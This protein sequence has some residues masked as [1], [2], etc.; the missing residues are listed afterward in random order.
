MNNSETLIM[1]PAQSTIASE[2]D[3]LFYFILYASIFMFLLVIGVT[4]FLLIKYRKRGRS[5]LTDG[6]DHKT[7][8]IDRLFSQHVAQSAHAQQQ[9]RQRQQVGEDYP[10]HDGKLGVQVAHQRWQSNIDDAAIYCRQ[11]DAHGH[12]SHDVPFS[13]VVDL[14]FSHAPPSAR[15]GQAVA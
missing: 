2:V 6:K 7:N 3:A 5:E 15:V 14:L 1:P 9:G 12:G 11:K 8:G 4:A 13:A 10:L